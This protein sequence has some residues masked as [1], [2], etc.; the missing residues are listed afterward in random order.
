MK[1]EVFPISEK[2]FYHRIPQEEKNLNIK[3]AFK[4]MTGR[5]MT[6]EELKEYVKLFNKGKINLWKYANGKKEELSESMS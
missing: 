4:E 5:D 3:T 6:D 2:I 1:E